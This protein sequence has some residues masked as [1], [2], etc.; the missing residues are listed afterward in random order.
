MRRTLSLFG[1]WGALL[2]GACGETIPLRLPVGV[3]LEVNVRETHT[4]Y[5]LAPDSNEYHKLDLWSQRNQSGWSRY[6]VTAPI[7]GICVGA[8]DVQLN[9]LGPSVVV[10]LKD[11]GGW[12]K[13][14][15]PADYAF[16]R[17]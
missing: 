4:H 8:G 3:P 13:A 6:Y 15:A 16:L 11:G 10:F 17:R 1:I 14:V 7:C 5:I 12:H 9:F 2:L